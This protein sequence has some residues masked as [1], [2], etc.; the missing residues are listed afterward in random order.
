MSFRRAGRWLAIPLALA[1]CTVKPISEDQAKEWSGLPLVTFLDKRYPAPVYPLY[2]V[3]RP[4]VSYTAFF[5]GGSYNLLFNPATDLGRYCAAQKGELLYAGKPTGATVPGAPGPDAGAALA[6][7]IEGRAFGQFACRSTSGGEPL[8]RVSVWPA[9]ILA[10]NAETMGSY[11]A[12]I[13][14]RPL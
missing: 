5:K 2:P 13:A 12:V 14:I 7:A 4:A 8:W 11:R 3:P 9:A 10:P 1:A 6:A